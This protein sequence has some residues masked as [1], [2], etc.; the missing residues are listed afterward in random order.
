MKSSIR[1]IF[2][3]S[4][5]LILSAI[6]FEV[7]RPVGSVIVPL[8]AEGGLGN[9]M[10]RY[11]AGYAL[12]KQTGSKLYVMVEDWKADKD[13]VRLA[14][15]DFNIDK[16]AIIYKNKI[17][18]QFLNRVYINE[19]NFFEV[20]QK[21]NYK[22][23]VIHDDFESEIFFQDY[24]K[25]ILSIFT[26]VIKTNK[27]QDTIDKVSK[28]DAVCVHVRRGDMS[29]N[30]QMYLISID[31]QLRAI[32]LARYLTTN[33]KFFIVSDSMDIAKKELGDMQDA[34]FIS[35]SPLEDFIIMTKCSN[36]IIA[37]ST[38]SWWAAYLNQNEN[39]LVIA[40]S[41]R[42]SNAVFEQIYKNSK[43]RE[44]KRE[45]YS[46]YSYPKDWI[47]LKYKD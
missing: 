19:N 11:A 44:E 18:K 8:Y 3:T 2:F 13:K 39:N 4:M 24:K 37:N 30:L 12:A 6:Y 33:P 22:T 43:R 38:F 42:Y 15:A 32:N 14:L 23:L 9:Q 5:A 36:N 17:N 28:E 34:S 26:P 20:N 47:A 45:F 10:F 1:I 46:K 25:D 16:S 40:P 7:P 29:R 35:G 21:Q 31:Y 41:P 27:I